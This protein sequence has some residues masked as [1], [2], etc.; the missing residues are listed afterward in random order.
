[1]PQIRPFIGPKCSLVCILQ[2][3]KHFP[4]W[5]TRDFWKVGSDCR[6]SNKK[7]TAG[8]AF[9]WEPPTLTWKGSLQDGRGSDRTSVCREGCYG[10]RS[11]G[12]WV[13]AILGLFLRRMF[14]QFLHAFTNFFMGSGS[15]ISSTHTW[16]T[17]SLTH[18]NWNYS[19]IWCWILS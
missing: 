9:Q 2:T 10:L 8:M 12:W 6:I 17:H 3:N 7:A 14:F 4:S 16:V 18:N 13:G 19:I 1:M 11:G 15:C 5:Q